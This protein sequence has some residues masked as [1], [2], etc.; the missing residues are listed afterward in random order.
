MASDVPGS[1]YLKPC[2]VHLSPAVKHGARYVGE[3]CFS[4]LKTECIGLISFQKVLLAG[5]IKPKRCKTPRELYFLR[6]KPTP[7][8]IRLSY[9]MQESVRA[10]CPNVQSTFS[11]YPALESVPNLQLI[12]HQR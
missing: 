3:E 8:N 2:Q 10:I 6:D 7:D 12:F 9:A 5:T 1:R 4:I 11:F